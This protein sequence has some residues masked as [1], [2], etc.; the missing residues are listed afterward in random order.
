M[1]F[2]RFAAA[3]ALVLGFSLGAS[4]VMAQAQGAKTA[5]PA[6]VPAF[7]VPKAMQGSGTSAGADVTE[8]L[9]H[10][11]LC[12]EKCT[13]YVL[14]NVTTGKCQVGAFAYSRCERSGNVLR[15]IGKGQVPVFLPSGMSNAA[16]S[17]PAGKQWVMVTLV[18]G[19]VKT[20]HA[21]I[22]KETTINVAFRD[23]TGNDPDRLEVQMV[24]PAK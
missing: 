2:S 15:A 5:I 17:F 12:K 8:L 11:S 9:D 16:N 21:G 22:P 4:A 24:A 19:V 3:A 18:N 7:A 13:G 20:H 6:P 14:W 10:A 23:G 1:T